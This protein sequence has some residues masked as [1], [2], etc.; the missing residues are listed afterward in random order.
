ME[1]FESF[2]SEYGEVKIAYQDGK[3]TVSL[4]EEQQTELGKAEAEQIMQEYMDS[5]G[6]EVEVGNAYE[7]VESYWSAH[8]YDA[9]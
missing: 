7:Y 8:I 9:E 5:L 4:T 3:V 6:E 2:R 1:K